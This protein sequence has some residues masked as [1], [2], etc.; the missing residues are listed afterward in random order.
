MSNSPQAMV[1]SF[2]PTVLPPLVAVVVAGMVSPLYSNE[3]F[4]IG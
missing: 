4:E 3:P 2:R 1:P